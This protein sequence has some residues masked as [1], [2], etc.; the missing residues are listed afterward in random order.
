LIIIDTNV[1]SEGM[2]PKPNANVQ[3]WIDA[4]QQ[5]SLFLCTPV[6]AE[7]F[8]GIERLP[9]GARRTHL[10]QA[11]L[12]MEA[13]F[14]DRVLGVDR[15]AA[16]EYGK[17]VGQR[18]HIGRATGTMDALIAAIARAHRATLATRDIYGFSD[19]EIDIVNPFDFDAA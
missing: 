12:R 1:I 13:T 16:V 7:L 15:A 3:A 6:L 4:Q 19:L 17:L 18:D 5:E 9:A 11:V 8:Y 2:R 14:A 10:E